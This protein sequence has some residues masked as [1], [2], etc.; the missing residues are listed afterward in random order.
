MASSSDG[1]A[2]LNVPA[3]VGSFKDTAEADQPSVS[4]SLQC[5]V[6][7]TLAQF[8]NVKTAALGEAISRDQWQPD[9]SSALCSYPLCTTNFG[10]ANN[11]SYFSLTP[12]RHHCRLCGHLFC[13]QH[14]TQRASLVVRTEDGKHVSKERVCDTCLPPAQETPL[15]ERQRRDS[16]WSE[17]SCST[18]PS[19]VI[20]TPEEE[21]PHV[22]ASVFTTSSKLRP[23]NR[24][25]LDVTVLPTDDLAPVE[26]WMGAEGILSLY[27]LAVN[28]SHASG[29]PVPC[30]AAG[31]LF[32]PSASAR[33]SALEKEMERLSLRQR[34]LGTDSFSATTKSAP[35]RRTL[36][37]A[38]SR[39][40]SRAASRTRSEERGRSS[41]SNSAISQIVHL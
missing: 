23:N 31:P 16:T 29:A 13:G 10:P 2:Y 9:G 21:P 25:H 12:R 35:T 3:L 11:Y 39:S 24:S 36:S 41:A 20:M 8:V 37:P 19:D 30:P 32:G 7:V 15:A 22:A 5:Q 33:R 17:G 14:T 1:L 26:P 40:S 38:L 27:P 6:A 18:V 34:R 4:T 28:A